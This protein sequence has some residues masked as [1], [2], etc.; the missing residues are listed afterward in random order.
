MA[1]A[2]W[3]VSDGGRRYRV[4]PH[5]SEHDVAQ[6][7]EQERLLQDNAAGRRLLRVRLEPADRIRVM[8]PTRSPVPPDHRRGRDFDL[9]T[10][11]VGCGASIAL[12]RSRLGCD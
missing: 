3:I 8:R 10:E 2:P 7:P 1:V 6:R 4:L 12:K 5:A 11:P 9:F